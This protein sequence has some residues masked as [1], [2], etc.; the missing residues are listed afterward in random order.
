LFQ[1]PDLSLQRFLYLYQDPFVAFF[2]V[3]IRVL[4]L[5]LITGT[6][7]TSIRFKASIWKLTV[8]NA[9]VEFTNG[10]GKLAV[11]LDLD[12]DLAVVIVGC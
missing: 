7:D 3:V 11:G 8:S 10:L 4:F 5:V 1:L 2:L 9:L 12:I 6:Q